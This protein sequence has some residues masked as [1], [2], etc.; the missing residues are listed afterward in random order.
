MQSTLRTK[1]TCGFVILAFGML[2]VD[3]CRLARSSSDAAAHAETHAII[4]ARGPN[5]F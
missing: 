4:M 2:L 5:R 3:M 1:V